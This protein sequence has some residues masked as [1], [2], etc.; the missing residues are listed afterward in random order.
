MI[1]LVIGVVR[2][3]WESA[4]P[5]VPCGEESDKPAIIADVHYLHFGI[6]LFGI[7]V[8]VAIVISLLT[9]PID[10]KHVSFE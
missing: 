2:F 4:Y 9:K 1:G 7:V 6:M 3:A 8:I 5:Q 10:K